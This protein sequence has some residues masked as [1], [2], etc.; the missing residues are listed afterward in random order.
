MRRLTSAHTEL[1]PALLDWVQERHEQLYF[2][3]R[4][5]TFVAVALLV[6][7][8]WPGAAVAVVP[9]VAA[10]VFLQAQLREH[11]PPAL[12]HLFFNEAAEVAVGD[13][14]GGDDAQRRLSDEPRRRDSG[15]E[16][17]RSED[18]D[19]QEDRGDEDE[20]PADEYDFDN[21]GELEE[22]WLHLD[23]DGLPI[24]A[25]GIVPIGDHLLEE[26]AEMADGACEDGDI[27]GLSDQMSKARLDLLFRYMASM[28]GRSQRDTS[29][30]PLRQKLQRK[31]LQRNA[32]GGSKAKA[33]QRAGAGAVEV[34]DVAG[35]GDAGGA[36]ADTLE[37]PSKIEELLRELGEEES[38]P[39]A[40]EGKTAAGVLGSNS[41][42][43]GAAGSASKKARRKGAG[44]A[45]KA[46]GTVRPAAPSTPKKA[47]TGAG[48]VADD[49]P[50]DSPGD[51]DCQD[52]GESPEA[53]RP[54]DRWRRGNARGS[55]PPSASSA[56]ASPARG[57]GGDA[58]R[59]AADE[60]SDDWE[61][62][63][64]LGH[65]LLPST[66]ERAT[67]CSS[68]HAPLARGAPVMRSSVSGWA[69]CKD[70]V[71][72]ARERPVEEPLLL[73]SGDDPARM[74]AAEVAAWFQRR[75][76]EDALRECMV[77]VLT[78]EAKEAETPAEASAEA[79]AAA[80]AR[81]AA[82]AAENGRRKRRTGR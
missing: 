12:Q 28:E 46:S 47:S 63:C 36:D 8:R 73:A 13:E 44:A 23:R 56:P 51:G 49:G 45:V 50:V 34:V 22:R 41:G 24:D 57:R 20:E 14:P 72:V 26:M 76:A 70:C 27:A 82:A 25:D 29:A 6:E 52:D 43:G 11:S 67:S 15:E 3:F 38:Q 4:L 30:N 66:A 7:Q 55:S 48:A 79:P 39:R 40:S 17:E 64:P 62:Q 77:R 37:D 58:L 19:G 71:L 69:A 31:L 33:S 32:A 42:S 74:T 60:D 61:W 78:A 18:V 80:A 21:G 65:P 35:G 59:E 53:E 5:A 54:S 75:G 16:R 2:A 1:L 68:C 10:V 9:G 81:R